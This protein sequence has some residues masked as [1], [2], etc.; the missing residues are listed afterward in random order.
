[1]RPTVLVEDNGL[2][3]RILSHGV[4]AVQMDDWRR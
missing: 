2:T 4:C 1:L 3:L